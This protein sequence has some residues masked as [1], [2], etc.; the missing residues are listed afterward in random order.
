MHEKHETHAKAL[1]ILGAF[2]CLGLFVCEIVLGYWAGFTENR[3]PY[4]ILIII[5]GTGLG[6]GSPIWNVIR[7]RVEKSEHTHRTP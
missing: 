5:A 1:R 4:E 7:N 6:F 3:L 2:V